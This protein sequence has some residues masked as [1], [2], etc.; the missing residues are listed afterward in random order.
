MKYITNNIDELQGS[1]IG[2]KGTLAYKD[3]MK[4]L[5]D[6][7]LKAML[8]LRKEDNAEARGIWQLVDKFIE[9]VKVL[10]QEVERKQKRK[11]QD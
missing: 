9:R 2:I 4:F 8:I 10:N 7:K 11:D 3:I 1:Y 6:E 5:G